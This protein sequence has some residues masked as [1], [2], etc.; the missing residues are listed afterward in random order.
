M[1][2]LQVYSDENSLNRRACKAMP[3]LAFCLVSLQSYKRA[4]LSNRFPSQLANLQDY[5][6]LP[7]SH[8]LSISCHSLVRKLRML[9]LPGFEHEPEGA[10]PCRLPCGCRKHH[11]ELYCVSC[12]GIPQ[13]LF[14]FSKGEVLMGEVRCSG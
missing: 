11:R 12:Q 5:H 13:R 14:L 4:F 8:R 6:R 9:Q 3:R 2:I 10:I 1:D 7:Q